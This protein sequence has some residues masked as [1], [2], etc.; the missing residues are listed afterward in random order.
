MAVG[1]G[2]VLIA[3]LLCAVAGTSRAGAAARKPGAPDV[4]I[5]VYAMPD[6]EDQIAFAYGGMIPHAQA[7]RDL[8]ALAAAVGGKMSGIKI[9]DAPP[10]NRPK[11]RKT[12]SIE[13]VAP[14]MFHPQAP[15]FTLD[16]FVAAF[17]SYQSFAVTFFM[18]DQA[19]A[20]GSNTYSDSYVN[21]RL[22]QTSSTA[23]YWVT[24][25]N[26]AYRNLKIPDLRT[27]RPVPPPTDVAQA[28]VRQP[29]RSAARPLLWATLAA[30]ITI[31]AGLFLY[32]LMA[33]QT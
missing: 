20:A 3:M 19:A 30:A 24:V 9:T 26:P 32:F 27:L 10:P 7:M 21:V 33:R 5:V 31:A 6:E 4:F 18:A 17:R 29:A 28:T 14:H 16:P 15:Q 2:A 22:D 12:T 25:K 13:A 11:G 23:T 1:F 8:N